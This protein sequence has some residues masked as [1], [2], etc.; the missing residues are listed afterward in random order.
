MQVQAPYTAAPPQQRTAPKRSNDI[1]KQFMVDM[2]SSEPDHVEA[3]PLQQ[4]PAAEPTTPV[5][6]NQHWSKLLH[7]QGTPIGAPEEASPELTFQQ[8]QALQE[9]YRRDMENYMAAAR[10]FGMEAAPVK[11][12]RGRPRKHPLP[13]GGIIPNFAA[14]MAN[15]SL[16]QQQQQQQEQPDQHQHQQVPMPFQM[17]SQPVQMAPIESPPNEAPMALPYKKQR[18]LGEAERYFQCHV[19]QA[20]IKRSTD[21]TRHVKAHDPGLRF[22]CPDCHRPFSRTDSLTR[23]RVNSCKVRRM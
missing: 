12:G 19:C 6:W 9:Q 8:F 10:D 2:P 13:N 18:F 17:P 15:L 21:F 4:V 20:I 3:S 22:E 1:F 7:P 16:Q 14:L 5:S 11:R 23:H